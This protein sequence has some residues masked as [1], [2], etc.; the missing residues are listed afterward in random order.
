MVVQ[1]NISLNTKI[2]A[3]SAFCVF[4]LLSSKTAYWEHEDVIREDIFEWNVCQ[5]YKVRDS[6]KRDLGLSFAENMNVLL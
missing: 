2:S 4:G 1:S 6:C 3:N 5:L